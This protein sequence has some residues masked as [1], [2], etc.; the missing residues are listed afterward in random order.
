MATEARE[1]GAAGGKRTRLIIDI[2][3]ALRRRI[4]LAAARRDVSVRDYVEGLLEQ[5]VPEET[6]SQERSRRRMTA[7]D[8]ALLRKVRE[9][10]SDGRVFPD[11]TPLIREMRE[12]RAEHLGRQ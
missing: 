8:A 12:E 2:S 10:I 5:A 9:D 7:E 6:P 3:P 4:R 1:E 11:S